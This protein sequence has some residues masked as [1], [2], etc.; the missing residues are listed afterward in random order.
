M[1][2]ESGVLPSL[3][4]YGTGLKAGV[5]SVAFWSAIILPFLHLPLLATGLESTSVTIAFTAL[6]AL[7]V[8]TAVVGHFH[9][10]E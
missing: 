2:A 9:R 5:T 1:L 6:V 8:L 7:N 3:S 4:R 10:A